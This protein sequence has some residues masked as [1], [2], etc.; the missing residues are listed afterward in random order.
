MNASKIK[1]ITK[2]SDS[3]KG[4]PKIYMTGHPAD[5]SKYFDR[6]CDDIFAAKDCVIYSL[7]SESEPLSEKE[8]SL[9]LSH[10]NLIVVIVTRRL[11]T[12]P[13]FVMQGEIDYAKKNNIPILPFMV[14]TGLEEIYSQEDMF[15]NLQY[16]AP[17]SCNKTEIPYDIKLKNYLQYTLFDDDT[18]KRIRGCFDAYIFLSYRKKDRA[19]AN[20]LLKLIHQKPEF[21][22]VSIWYDEFLTLGESFKENIDKM[23]LSSELFLLLVTPQLLEESNGKPNFIMENEFPRAKELG[24]KILPVEMEKTDRKSLCEKF[25]NIPNCVN[26]NEKQ[27]FWDLMLKSLKHIARSADSKDATHNFLIGLA[28][29][30]GIDMEVD[31]ARGFELIKSAA[32]NNL[33]EAMNFIYNAFEYGLYGGVDYAAAVYWGKKILNYNIERFGEESENSI[34]AYSNLSRT[35]RS[36]GDVQNELQSMEKTFELH[37]KVFGENNLETLKALSNLAITYNELKQYGKIIEL[38]KRV[39]K[40]CLDLIGKDFD[41]YLFSPEI[42]SSYICL[43]ASV[44][45]N[46]MSNLYALF[47]Y[48]LGKKHPDTI[49]AA[50]LLSI[51]YNSSFASDKKLSLKMQKKICTLINK[52]FGEKSLFA[53]SELNNLATR[54]IANEN[55]KKAFELLQKVYELYCQNLGKNHPDTVTILSNIAVCYRGLK[56]YQ[57]A[58]KVQ[59]RVCKY[60]KQILG[61]NHPITL[62]SLVR[63]GE[64]YSFVGKPQTGIRLANKAYKLQLATLNEGNLDIEDTLYTLSRLYYDVNDKAR[65]DKLWQQAFAYSLKYT[66]D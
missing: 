7:K 62:K 30:Y 35:Y 17:F 2:N 56:D 37:V 24:V 58:L 8:I 15:G 4:K 9:F 55:Y 54:Y 12:E 39:E 20:E 42:S 32:G 57:N 1:Y 26:P 46:L 40:Q 43:D 49:T 38:D 59:K 66:P 31:R 52:A 61:E 36:F 11:L 48:S 47:N 6:F 19:Y 16:V 45:I 34:I 29:L 13:N 5:F 63:L 23:L 60:Q 41:K 44:I 22:S 53:I 64:F 18:V 51:C 65:S 10:M 14:H 3:P 27:A 50:C 25:V 21:Q 28:Y 33:Y